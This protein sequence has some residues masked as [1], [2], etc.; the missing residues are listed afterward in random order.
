M[1]EELISKVKAYVDVENQKNS[2][3]KKER[4]HY[5]QESDFIRGIIV[6]FFDEMESNTVASGLDDLGRPFRLLNNFKEISI[7]KGMTQQQVAVQTNIDP[8]NISHIW[9]NKTQPSLDYFLRIWICL[10]CPPLNKCLYREI[11]K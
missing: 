8:G 9:R 7:K 6:D 3:W 4:T 2:L 5:I 1:S 10:D 11:E